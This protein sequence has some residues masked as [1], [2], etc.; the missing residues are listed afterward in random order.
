MADKLESEIIDAL[1]TLTM[2]VL[3][4]EYIYDEN[5]TRIRL[6]LGNNCFFS[7]VIHALVKVPKYIHFEAKLERANVGTGR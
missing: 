5:T 6:D 4:S 3:V 7:F 1:G 2:D